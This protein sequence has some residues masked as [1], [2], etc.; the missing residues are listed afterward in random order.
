MSHNTSSLR[1]VQDGQPRPEK[2]PQMKLKPHEI[3]SKS[4]SASKPNS[5]SL[6]K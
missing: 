6:Q 3:P 5:D 2:P 1:F 4:P